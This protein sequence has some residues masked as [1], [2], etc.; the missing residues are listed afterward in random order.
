MAHLA[1][2]AGGIDAKRLW[3]KADPR[4][5]DD[6]IS[7]MSALSFASSTVRTGWT[8]AWCCDRHRA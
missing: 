8:V 5:M 3:R 1:Y 6:L 2:V 4:W 7:A